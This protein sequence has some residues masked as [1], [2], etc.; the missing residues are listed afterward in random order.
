MAQIFH[1]FLA[2][3]PIR[4]ERKTGTFWFIGRKTGS[5]LPNE[6][7][8]AGQ[9]KHEANKSKANSCGLVRF[10]R[11]WAIADVSH[12]DAEKRWQYNFHTQAIAVG[13][14]GYNIKRFGR[15]NEAARETVPTRE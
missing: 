12:G 8:R 4:Q 7:Q 1:G 6:K 14:T 5:E 11:K 15:S 10:P 2:C 3:Q 13:R 9:P